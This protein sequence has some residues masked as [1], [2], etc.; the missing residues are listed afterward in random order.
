MTRRSAFR[1]AMPFAVADAFC[2]FML[3]P[4]Y[5]RRLLLPYAAAA[6]A[7]TPRYLPHTTAMPYFYAMFRFSLFFLIPARLP[8]SATGAAS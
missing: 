3:M 1:A 4:P 5:A 8:R 2:F 6:A 7:D